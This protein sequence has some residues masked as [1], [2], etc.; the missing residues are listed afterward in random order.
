MWQETL[1]SSL[2]HFSLRSNLELSANHPR[3]LPHRKFADRQSD[4]RWD[5][6]WGQ[7]LVGQLERAEGKKLETLLN[8][9]YRC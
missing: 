4:A 8:I 9:T 3:K 5:D 1:I 2:V 7:H 6:Q